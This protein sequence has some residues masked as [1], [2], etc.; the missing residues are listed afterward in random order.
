MVPI[1]QIETYA[2]EV[3]KRFRPEKIILFGSHAYGHPEV[4]SDVDLL[5][6][7]DHPGRPPY[8]EAKI[9]TTVRA[10]FAVDLMVRTPSRLKRRL[11]MKDSFITEIIDK[12]RVLHEG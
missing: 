4:D 5:V 6:I 9:R 1:S 10:P 11:A 2:R 7:M 12:G 8:Q 3:A